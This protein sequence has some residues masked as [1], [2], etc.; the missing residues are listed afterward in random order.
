MSRK[1]SRADLP[2]DNV[3]QELWRRTDGGSPPS[4][5][6]VRVDHHYCTPYRAE[7][8]D[9]PK[10]R[11]VAYCS[12][13]SMRR[14]AFKPVSHYKHS[15]YQASAPGWHKLDSSPV[16]YYTQGSSV[17][18]ATWKSTSGVWSDAEAHVR[19]WL[20]AKI[21]SVVGSY[22]TRHYD[23]WKLVKPTMTTRANMFVF[24]GELRDLKRMWDVI[25][26]KHLSKYDTWQ[27]V[28]SYLIRYGNNAHLNF[29]F[30]W[31]PFSRDVLNSL[32]AVES[33]ERRLTKFQSQAN[34]EMRKRYGDLEQLVSFDE[35]S[36]LL[37]GSIWRVRRKGTVRYKRA[38][39]FDFV[40]SLPEYGEKELRTRAWLDTFGLRPSFA[41][42]W[43][44]V[45]RSFVVDW[46]WNVGGLLDQ[47]STDWIEPWVTLHQA[48]YSVAVEVEC[49]W[50]ILTPVAYGSHDLPAYNSS[51]SKYLR[52]V[53][54]PRFSGTTDP[55]DAD[56]IRLGA[57]LILGGAL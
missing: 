27:D 14:K 19:A 21:D 56:K 32:K 13:P 29:E 57:S 28:K 30:G 37:Q 23:R 12:K 20:D 52:F 49:Q 24:L 50:S 8:V 11:Y 15:L 3:F 25:P 4:G 38:S 7:I 31:K 36:Q 22:D 45:T 40:Y 5:T 1:R 17:F 16:E 43:E 9:E 44:L 33:F 48:M 41:N 39:S 18:H 2:I 34:R 47:Y 42:M 26:K 10:T 51:Y 6:G 54:L 55:L 53:G 35:T 46:F